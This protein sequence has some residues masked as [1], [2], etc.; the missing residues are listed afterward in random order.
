MPFV[1]DQDRPRQ[2]VELVHVGKG[3]PLLEGIEQIKQ[4]THRYGYFGRAHF[5]EQIEQHGYCSGLSDYRDG[6]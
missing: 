5:I 3:H 1:L 4:L 6:S 2:E